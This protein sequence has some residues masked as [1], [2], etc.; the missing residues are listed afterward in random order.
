M[1]FTLTNL[2]HGNTVTEILNKRRQVETGKSFFKVS[3][4]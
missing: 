1:N 2:L 3:R 4:K